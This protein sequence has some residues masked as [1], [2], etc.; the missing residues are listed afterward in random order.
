M[1][2]PPTRP[3]SKKVAKAASPGGKRARNLRLDAEALRRAEAYSR[4]HGTTVSRLVEDYLLALTREQ[5]LEDKEV[6]SPVARELRGI[7]GNGLGDADNE[8]QLWR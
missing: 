5:R 8:K 4:K 6:L 2:K 1:S 3:E 7:A